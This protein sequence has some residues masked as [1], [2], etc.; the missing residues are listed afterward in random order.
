MGY[1]DMYGNNLVQQAKLD[2]PKISNFL[3]TISDAT[4]KLGIIAIL[5]EEHTLKSLDRAWEVFNNA[6]SE[7]DLQ[8]IEAALQTA[9]TEI[10]E[11]NARGS[12]YWDD[13]KTTLY[14]YALQYFIL[15]LN[16]VDLGNTENKYIPQIVSKLQDMHTKC[17]EL[18]VDFNIMR[19]QCITTEYQRPN[20]NE[21]LRKFKFIDSKRVDMFNT[22]LKKY[23]VTHN[24]EDLFESKNDYQI[25]PTSEQIDIIIKK[26]T[27]HLEQ[28]FHFKKLDLATFDANALDIMCEINSLFKTADPGIITYIN[29]VLYRR[30]KAQEKDQNDNKQPTNTDRM[31]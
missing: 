31:I 17:D 9:I 22:R 8:I 14:L 4:A 11:F 15:N 24:K 1:Y 7:H 26:L 12:K 5:T 18:G 19:Q 27:T 2:D 29:D 25:L 20:D 30:L 23:A 6:K 3:S 16:K 10:R 13:G 21:D 28:K